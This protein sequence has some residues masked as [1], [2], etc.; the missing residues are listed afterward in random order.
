MEPFKNRISEELA[1]ELGR[2]VRAVYPEFATRAYRAKIRGQ[3]EALELKARAQ[4][5]GAA[6]WERL[7]GPAGHN[8]E[9]LTAA[10]DSFPRLGEPGESAESEGWMM[11]PMDQILGE[12]GPKALEAALSFAK[13]ITQRFTAEFG[14]RSLWL[15]DRERTLA[16][17]L[18]WTQHPSEHVRRLASEGTRPRLPWGQQLPDV[19]ADP[20]WTRPILEA[21]KGDPSEYVRRSVSNHWNDLAKD[22]P[23][24][25]LDAME[26]WWSPQ[27][28]VRRKL[29]RHACRTL[30]KA[31][32]PRALKLQGFGPPRLREAQLTL[33][34]KRFTLGG[35]LLA[36]VRLQAKRGEEQNLVVDFRFHLVRAKGHTGTKVFKGRTLRLAGGAEVILE[37]RFPLKPVTTRRY[38]RGQTRVELLVNGAVLAEDSFHLSVP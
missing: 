24:Y 27:D 36:S 26:A 23:D 4:W 5:V 16:A 14:I 22:H 32:H 30:V 9:L 31:G 8:L 10:V 19:I 2:R 15:A 11:F 33:K 6:L 20:E 21:L 29:V 35:S 7:P 25:V 1:F 37:Q 38:H 3:L 18:E 34:P 17:L 13:A 12:H 28:P